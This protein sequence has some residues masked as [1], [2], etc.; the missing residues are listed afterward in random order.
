M[1]KVECGC[2]RR[3]KRLATTMTKHMVLS[4]VKAMVI[5]LYHRKLENS[6]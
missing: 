1:K 6:H 5:F 2:T 3:G 4:A